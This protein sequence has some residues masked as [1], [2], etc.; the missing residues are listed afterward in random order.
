MQLRILGTA[1]GG[2][3]PQW[4]CN[5][6]YCSA[7][8]R[9]PLTVPRRLHASVAL[10]VREGSW[11]IV[12][13]TPDIRLQIEDTLELHPGPGTRTTPIKGIFL[14]DA[15]LDHTTGLLMLREGST[16]KVFASQP[17]L[18]A[19][20]TS[21]PVASILANYSR[22]DWTAVHCGQSVEIEDGLLLVHTFFVDRKHPRYAESAA[23]DSSSE[24]VIGYRFQD[25]VS[26]GSLAVVPQVG[27]FDEALLE[28]VASADYILMDGTFCYEDDL[29]R[30]GIAGKSASQMGHLPLCGDNGIIGGIEAVNQL[31]LRRGKKRA[32][33]YLTHINNTNPALL[34]DAE[35]RQLL[36]RSAIDIVDDGLSLSI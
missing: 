7:A 27:R 25:T 33:T 32:T 34:E 8:R 1:A 16:F 10:S 4:N 35:E 3:F 20:S 14:T 19:L 13:A 36:R 21:F 6:K 17:I 24:W 2:G 5:C 28:E 29:Q 26:G 15:E 18:K 22:F 9:S 30:A 31:R 23:H 11:F 12:N